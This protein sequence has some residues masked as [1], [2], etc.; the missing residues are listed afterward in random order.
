M[1]GTRVTC[2]DVDTRDLESIVIENDYVVIVDGNRY[3]DGV[4]NYPGSGTSVITI[5]TKKD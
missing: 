3:V 4:Q 5:K 1:P 2:E